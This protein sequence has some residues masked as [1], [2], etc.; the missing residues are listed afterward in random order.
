MQQ[1]LNS[2]LTRRGTASLF[3]PILAGMALLLP[4][5]ANSSSLSTFTQ[6][7]QALKKGDTVTY[8]RLKKQL[9][10]YP[11]LPYLDYAEI[12]QDRSKPLKEADVARFLE[13]YDGSGPAYLLR[14]RWLKQLAAAKQWNSYLKWY[15]EGDSNIGRKCHYLTALQRTGKGK[16]TH[17]EVDEIWDYGRS[18]PDACDPLFSYWRQQ[19]LLTR[20]RVWSRADKAMNLGQTGIATHLAKYLSKGDAELVRTFAKLRKSPKQNLDAVTAE[21]PWRGQMVGYGLKRLAYQSPESAVKK[22]KQIKKRHKL[23]PSERCII[24]ERLAGGLY[25]EPGKTVYGFFKESGACKSFEDLHGYRVK[26]ALLREDW[27]RVEAW[28]GKM[29]SSQAE[30]PEWRYWKARA[31]EQQGEKVAARKIYRDIARDRSFYAYLAS[32]RLGE[33]YHFAHAPAPVSKDDRKWLEA[34][35]AMLRI[36]ELDRLGRH[37]EMRREWNQLVKRLDEQQK[38]AAAT[39]FHE[40]EIL[41]RAIFTLAKSGYWDDLEIRFPVKHSDLVGRY[42]KTRK[43]DT[44]WAFGI[45]RQ[46]SAFMRDANSS[47]GARGLMQLMPGT[48]KLVSKK[49]GLGSTTGSDLIRPDRN[50][51]LGTGY[52]RMMLDRFDNNLTLATASYNAGPGRAKRWQYDRALPADIWVELIPFKETRGY[53]KNVMTYAS[54][55]DRRLENGKPLKISERIGV[56][57]ARKG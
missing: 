38:I 5:L 37:T 24:E 27:K 53:V 18:R 15:D 23:S 11:L 20:D 1:G 14:I 13:R 8:K 2:R 50:I 10:D 51:A 36:R 28:V 19:G 40:W 47:A 12:T 4:S 45:L 57:P 41:D 33:D 56:I 3:I 32:D 49:Y 43:L 35:P 21:H 17:S 42:A 55:Y 30:E 48:A 34:D 54:I 25:R 29:P 16:K 6:A 46:E 52:L 31:L 26:A 7:E 22:W 39:L 9:A 44:S